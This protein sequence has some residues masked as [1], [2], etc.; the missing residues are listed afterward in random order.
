MKYFSTAFVKTEKPGK[1]ISKIANWGWA[2]ST[3]ASII[4]CEDGEHAQE[5]VSM[6]EQPLGAAMALA[7]RVKKGS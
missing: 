5:A 2:P 3:P 6:V 1:N 7:I 4:G